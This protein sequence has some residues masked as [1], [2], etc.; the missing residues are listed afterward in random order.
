MK[1][2]KESLTVIVIVSMMNIGC[3]NVKHKNNFHDTFIVY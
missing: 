3:V 2:Y 1:E